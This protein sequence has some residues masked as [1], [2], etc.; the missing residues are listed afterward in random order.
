MVTLTSC[1]DYP[2]DGHPFEKYH[3]F[4]YATLCV[5]QPITSTSITSKPGEIRAVRFQN[6]IPKLVSRISSKTRRYRPLSLKL[7]QDPSSHSR[8]LAII[9]AL[10]VNLNLHSNDLNHPR[11]GRVNVY[12]TIAV[13][14]STLK[15]LW[16]IDNLN[17]PI[18]AHF[19]LPVG[20]P[21]ATISK[22]GAYTMVYRD[23]IFG[24]RFRSQYSESTRNKTL[25]LLTFD[26]LDGKLRHVYENLPQSKLDPSMREAYFDQPP[27][28]ITHPSRDL[29]FLP[30]EKPSTILV[31]TKSRTYELTTPNVRTD[32]GNNSGPLI[33]TLF[34][35]SFDSSQ[36]LILAA[37]YQPEFPMGLNPKHKLM[38]Q[39]TFTY[40]IPGDA[41]LEALETQDEEMI[42]ITHLFRLRRARQFV[43]PHAV[44]KHKSDTGNNFIAN[45][46]DL[47]N[48][49]MV[50]F[51]DSGNTIGIFS[52]VAR[53][54]LADWKLPEYVVI[55]GPERICFEKFQIQA[56]DGVAVTTRGGK[57][58]E[59]GG[60]KGKGW[61]AGLEID[62]GGRAERRQL[63]AVKNWDVWVKMG[64]EAAVVW[65][66]DEAVWLGFGMGCKDRKDGI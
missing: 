53:N 33:H 11:N 19:G 34:R 66:G 54:T 48:R 28:I 63:P 58:K 45:S 20:P 30:S 1:K 36:S 7:W 4:E 60:G 37:S 57:T 49:Q 22:T 2:Q 42:N 27:R 16:C 59:R 56:S 8:I 23:F 6:L 24:E 47:E 25:R 40:D 26:V 52:C 64:E 10:V 62:D 12:L 35:V 44:I 50:G 5:Q 65:Q 55:G 3:A 43:I 13:D 14:I 31:V 46:F 32:S 18:G 29:F 38:V 15:T 41:E 39:F 17:P 9:Q 21:D 51:L 61:K